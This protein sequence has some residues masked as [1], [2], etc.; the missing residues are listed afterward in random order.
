MKKAFS[1]IEL[2]TVL[3][4]I[5]ILS[6]VTYVTFYQSKDDTKYNIMKSTFQQLAEF[7][8]NFYNSNT[9]FA[10][11]GSVIESYLGKGDGEKLEITNLSSSDLNKI[12]I[13]KNVSNTSAKFGATTFDGTYCYRLLL[14]YQ[15]SSNEW[16]ESISRTTTLTCSGD[17]VVL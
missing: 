14:N 5:I 15:V 16:T 17:N 13:S 8:K 11:S 7:Q 6:G 12:S 1:L 10:T 4:L 2:S 3:L 9:D